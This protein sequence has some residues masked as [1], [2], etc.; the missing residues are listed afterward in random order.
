MSKSI[1][2]SDPTAH[3]QATMTSLSESV[4]LSEEIIDHKEMKPFQVLFPYHGYW[5]TRDVFALDKED[6]KYMLQQ[7]ATKGTIRNFGQP[8]SVFSDCGHSSR[9]CPECEANKG[10]IRIISIV[11]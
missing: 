6:A 5:V 2:K 9:T 11:P 7:M 8:T 3:P 10:K 4:T 1:Q